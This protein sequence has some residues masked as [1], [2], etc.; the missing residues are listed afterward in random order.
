MCNIHT[1]SIQYT[2]TFEFYAR[3]T[4]LLFLDNHFLVFTHT[5]SG[6]F[7]LKSNRPNRGFYLVIFSIFYRSEFLTV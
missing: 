4:N 5:V 7:Y 6:E 1:Y 3:D 2:Y